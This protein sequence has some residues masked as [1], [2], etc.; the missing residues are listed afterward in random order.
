MK[1]GIAVSCGVNPNFN[2][3]KSHPVRYSFLTSHVSLL[4]PRWL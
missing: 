2:P 3:H 4:G 1:D